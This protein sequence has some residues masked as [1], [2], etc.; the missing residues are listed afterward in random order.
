MHLTLFTCVLGT[1]SAFD[2]LVCTRQ[3]QL[4]E[5]QVAQQWIQVRTDTHRMEA[6][7]QTLS[8]H[9]PV[10]ALAFCN[11]KAA[12]RELTEYLKVA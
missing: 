3:T 2:T 10:Q 1:L 9:K 8:Q 7:A 11:T 12:C 4:S 6:V 5:T